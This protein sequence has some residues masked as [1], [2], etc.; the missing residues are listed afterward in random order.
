ML[1]NVIW[2]TMQYWYLKKIYKYLVMNTETYYNNIPK[3]EKSVRIF[4]DT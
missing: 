3:P 4:Y 2:Q 1:E